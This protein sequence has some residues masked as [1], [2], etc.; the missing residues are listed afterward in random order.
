VT[1]VRRVALVGA[2]S[3]GKST[4]AERLA[5]ELGT[6][7]VPEYGR[8]YCET[9]N[10]LTLDQADL[11]A[12]AW[13]QATWE[14]EAAERASRVLI[15][16]TEL[17]T[18][19]TWSDLTIG[20]RPAWMTAAARA[21]PYDLFLLLEDDVPWVGDGVR[22]IP[23]RRAH[24]T[25]MLRDELD[26]A[27]RRY[28]VVRGDWETRARLAREAID[29]L[30]AEGDADAPSWR[31]ALLARVDAD[32]ALRAL[33]A[34]V[35]ARM[36]TD[37]SHDAEH[38]LRVAHWAERLAPP[39]E[40]RLAIAAALLH[41]VVNV[42]KGSP[43]RAR[44]SE[45]SADVA[46]A[47]LPP[48]GFTA[49]E[50]ALVADAVRD[51]SYTRG[52]APASPLGRAVQDADRLEALGAI[53]VFRCVATGERLGA[54]FSHPGDPWAERRALD[55]R[56]YSVDHFFTKLLRLPATFHTADGRAEAERRAAVMRALLAAYGD[57]IGV[58]APPRRA[59]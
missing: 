11:E 9:V 47:L 14:D 15:C 44:A 26:A 5:R 17:H 34:E 55:D 19:C 49:D 36:D 18:T 32:P 57:E 53:G 22:V 3:V 12:I 20:T 59:P 13:G 54:A 10:A 30:L 28:L 2:E 52:A 7:W 1:A 23:E 50:T 58:P 51:H 24:H 41:D 46:R 16:D 35:R 40:R 27:G 48:L 29:A 45:L 21:R 31:D 4:L 56:A 25:R 42:P 6:V 33:L 39:H 37:A 43:D 8:Q 38:L